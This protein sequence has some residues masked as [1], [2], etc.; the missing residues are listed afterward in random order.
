[1]GAAYFRRALARFLFCASISILAS[2]T[3]AAT[4]RTLEH[5]QLGVTLLQLEGEIE[6][7]DDERIRKG[8]AELAGKA[9]PGQLYLS[10]RS[11]GGA[12]DTALTIAKRLREAG[13]GTI[14][15]PGA[16]C[17]SACAMIFFGGYSQEA[18]APRRIAF[19]GSRLGVHRMQVRP[20]PGLIKELQAKKVDPVVIHDVAQER[21]GEM[22]AAMLNLEISPQVLARMFQTPHRAM[23]V[24]TPSEI[25]GAGIVLVSGRKGRWHSAAP[26]LPETALPPGL[27]AGRIATVAAAAGPAADNARFSSLPSAGPREGIVLV[28]G[29]AATKYT[30]PVKWSRTFNC[31]HADPE[32]R[33]TLAVSLC[34]SRSRGASIGLRFRREAIGFPQDD[35]PEFRGS[36]RVEFRDEGGQRAGIEAQLGR[37]DGDSASFA[38]ESFGRGDLPALGNLNQVVLDLEPLRI[39]LSPP[40]GLVEAAWGAALASTDGS[41]F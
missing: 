9:P 32:D 6:K 33:T 28:E 14:V 3:E 37:S 22:I 38:T 41:G 27:R 25:A 21:L 36:Y 29:P 5:D 1:M 20:R 35:A 39:A 16:S 12:V 11:D 7:D 17:Y 18:R 30:V 23:H 13:I 40:R 10:L 2:A 8:L 4:I 31:L 26:L 34:M 15:L 24:L 19:V